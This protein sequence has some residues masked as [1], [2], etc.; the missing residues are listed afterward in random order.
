[1][2][3][4]LS[5][6]MPTRPSQV[7]R[8]I[9]VDVD[10]ILLMALRK[11]PQLR[12]GSVEQLAND[13]RRYLE[14][15][16]VHA[17]GNSLRYRAGKFL[18]RRKLEIAAGAMVL[19]A[20][21]GGL[22]IAI[23]EARIA[24]QQ[25]QVAQQ[26]FDSVRK[27]ANTLLFDIHDEMAKVS[28]SIRP[29]EMLVGTALEYL[30]TL[31]KQAGSDRRLQ[32]ELATA[33]SKVALIQGNDGGAN[34]GDYKGALGSYERSVALFTALVKVEPGNH[35]AGWGLANAYVEQAALVLV[36]R[37]PKY[38]LEGAQKGVALTELHA[39]AI[40]DEAERTRHLGDAYEVYARVLGFMGRSPE[41]VDL[42]DKLIAL[43]ERYWRAHSEDEGALQA[44]GEAYN[45]SALV[46]DTRLSEAKSY[47]R[48]VE[49][50][51]KAMW[52]D[53]KLLSLKP[54]DPVYQV[55]MANGRF[56]SAN[57]LWARKQYAESLPLFRLAAP[58]IT[59]AALDTNNV[60]AQYRV[61]LI[62]SGLARALFKT[63]SVEEARVLFLECQKVLD[64]VLARD[65][66]LRTEFA[67][68]QN[69]VRLGELYAYLAENRRGSRDAQLGLWKQARD[70]LQ[71]GVT[72]VQKVTAAATLEAIDRAVLTDGVAALV[73][74]NSVIAGLES[75]E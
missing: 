19:A 63:G 2:A 8:K 40:G 54:D 6:T 3:E 38:A 20:L 72:S 66:S 14:G 17:R 27:L 60:A 56:N 23:R 67:V 74:A 25:R 31:Y 4:I 15:M 28:G 42:F 5:D 68:G 69:A 29:R 47:E 53:E 1:M 75:Q 18:R 44:L 46:A 52:V 58:P 12:Y 62:N 11:E 48:A 24:E 41:A 43:R 32:E 10:N 49:L 16:P 57:L 64:A 33:Y 7:Q 13:L 65:G 59:K 22:G 37:G 34:R 73:H 45:D 71:R 21:L 55:R 39:P 51:R 61:G 35:R 36:A 70:S 30:D 9:E 26:H 50:L